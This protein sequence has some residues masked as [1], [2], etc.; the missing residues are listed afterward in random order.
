MYGNAEIAPLRMPMAELCVFGMNEGETKKLLTFDWVSGA[1]FTLVKISQLAFVL[2]S[3][4]ATRLD[5]GM[6]LE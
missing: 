6:G 5:L 1:A 3:V 4:R 2:G